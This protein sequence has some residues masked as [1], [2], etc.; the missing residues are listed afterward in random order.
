MTKKKTEKNVS[1]GD[2]KIVDDPKMRPISILNVEGRIFF[3]VVNKRL[4]GFLLANGYIDT[5]IQKGFIEN[6]PG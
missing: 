5:R 1:S 6:F 3:T 2:P 4:A